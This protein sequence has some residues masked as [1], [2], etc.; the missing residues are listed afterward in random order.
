MGLPAN[1]YCE[2]LSDVIWAEPINALSNGAFLVS[3]FAVHSL[4]KKHKLGGYY[5]ILPF[6][7]GI[8]TLGSLLWHT[9]RNPFSQILDGGLLYI[10]IATLVLFLLKLLSG[11]WVFACMGVVSIV[12]LQVAIFLFLPALR[13]TPIRHV[14][15]L[16]I[17]GV[18]AVWTVKKM[19]RVSPNMVIALSCYVMAIVAKAFDLPLCSFI[20]IGTHFLWHV[21]GAVAGYY[22]VA[23]LVEMDNSLKE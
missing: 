5:A 14:V 15:A 11:R 23:A 9:V 22:S 10:F 18:I 3:A 21:F 13:D 2:R 16:L 19:R 4:L 1:N 7:L 6:Q 8:V 17:F 20:P 12:V